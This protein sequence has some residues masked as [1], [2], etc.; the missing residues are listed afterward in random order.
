MIGERREPRARLRRSSSHPDRKGRRTRSRPAADAAADLV[1]LR[2]TEHVGALDDRAYSP[3]G[4]EPRLDDRRRHEHVGVAAQERVHPLLELAL[5]H[6][7]VRDEEAQIRAELLQLLGRLVDRLDAVLQVEGLAAPLLLTRER[8]PDQSSSYSPDRVR[9]G[10]GLRRRLDDRDV[11]R[12]RATCAASRDRR[13][14]SV[15]T[16][17]SMRSELQLLLLDAEAL[18]LV[19]DTGP[20]LRNDVA[21]ETR[22]VPIGHVDLPSAKSEECFVS[23]L[24]S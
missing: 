22:C 11:A 23:D 6:L 8:Q 17:T 5:A 2:E 13:R 7:P 18:L 10:R 1:E 4:C 15:S 12:P 24:R 3:A 9:I 19:E 20:S 21:R 16:S 14:G